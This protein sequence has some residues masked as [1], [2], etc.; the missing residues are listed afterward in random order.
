MSQEGSLNEHPN[1]KTEQLRRFV[2]NL[3]FT[4][5]SPSSTYD[6]KP[7]QIRLWFSSI[8]EQ[9]SR[10]SFLELPWLPKVEKCRVLRCVGKA[11]DLTFNKVEVLEQADFAVLPFDGE[12]LVDQPYRRKSDAA[13]KWTQEFVS[14][15]HAKNVPVIAVVT[16]DSS[17][18]LK[19]GFDIVIR[20]S[21]NMR[22]RQPGEYCLP[23]WFAAVQDPS[24]AKELPQSPRKD[25]PRVGF[26]GHASISKSIRRRLRSLKSYALR[27]F[28]R[29]GFG[30][31]HIDANCLRE[32]VL[33]QL[34][35][36]S[37]LDCVFSRRDA[38]YNRLQGKDQAIDEYV[39]NTLAC[40][41]VVCPRGVGNY[42]FRFYDTLALGRVPILIDTDTSLPYDHLVDYS[43]LLPIVRYDALCEAEHIIMQHYQNFA[44]D[45]WQE[46]LVDLRTFYQ[47]WLAPRGF[48]NRLMLIPE[49]SQRVKSNR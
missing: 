48:F 11:G 12:C 16:G 9:F 37:S 43:S 49:I 24:D 45:G 31:D 42:S 34:E 47:E 15:C 4:S 10:P 39:K 36:C 8:P 20:H 3:H 35:R 29:D 2:K 6:A 23:G 17:A 41:Y 13:S 7:S 40:D 33:S 21:I 28:Y 22:R 25:R 44:S 46:M 27:Q 1:L 38:Y 19:A 26:C 32:E 18:P 5:A 14:V 30:G